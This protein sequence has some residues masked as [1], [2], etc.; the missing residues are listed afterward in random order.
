MYRPLAF[1]AVSLIALGALGPSQ[2][3]ADDVPT[4]KI[5]DQ[6]VGTGDAARDDA[7]VKINY[8]GW[9][10]DAKAPDHHGKEF[11]SSYDNGEPL[12]FTVGADE[13]IEGMESGVRGMKVG[14]KREIIIPSR[15]GYGIRGAG[16]DIPPGSALVFDIELLSVQ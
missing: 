12:T 15:E 7:T 4:L 2:A 1:L 6:K 11:D 13:V 8:T 9:L 16:S 10:Y 14:G 3:R 5:T